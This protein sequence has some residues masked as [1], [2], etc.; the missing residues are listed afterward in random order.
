MKVLRI[1]FTKKTAHQTTR[2]THTQTDT[3][4]DPTRA[5]WPNV[6]V[7]DVCPLT[8]TQHQQQQNWRETNNLVPLIGNRFYLICI[9]G[10][11]N[12]NDL[13]KRPLQ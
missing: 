11:I 7:G 1:S 4:I 9:P 10:L 5:K 13:S 6:L 2:R 12:N 3:N 8:P